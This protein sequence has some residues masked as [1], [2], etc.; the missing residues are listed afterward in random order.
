MRRF[1]GWLLALPL[2]LTGCAQWGEAAP[3]RKGEALPPLHSVALEGGALHFSVTSHGCTRAEDFV[4]RREG[5][6][7]AIVRLR[8]DLC[9][10]AP[11]ARAIRLPLPE[12]APVSW[13]LRNPLA[14]P[15]GKSGGGKVR[16]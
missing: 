8:P 1:D 7:L 6:G 9:R 3:P 11:F 12:G 4:I 13:R 2:A 14:P 5:E 16:R 15:P 10:R